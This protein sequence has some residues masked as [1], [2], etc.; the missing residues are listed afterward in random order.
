MRKNIFIKSMLRRP[1][2]T[3][4]L[5]ALI[6]L[7]TFAFVLRTVEFVIVRSQIMATAGEYRTLGFI[8]HPEWFGD[9]SEGIELISSSPYIARTHR[10]RAAEGILVD[11]LNADFSGMRPTL[12]QRRGGREN[13]PRLTE[14]YI[15]A[16]VLDIWGQQGWMQGYTVL[17]LLVDEVI[18]GHPEYAINGQYMTM[19]FLHGPFSYSDAF[20]NMVIGERYL[21]VG[22]YLRQYPGW[23]IGSNHPR[24]PLGPTTPVEGRE[25]DWLYI[26][27]LCDDGRPPNHTWYIHAPTGQEADFTDPRLAHIPAQILT[28]YRDQRSLQLQAVTDMTMMPEVTHAMR[29]REGRL[30]D[31]YDYIEANPVAVIDINF[32][33]NR[34]LE[35]GDTFKINI[36]RQQ[37]FVGAVTAPGFT[38]PL[39]RVDRAY[40]HRHEDA[41][42]VELTVVGITSFNTFTRYTTQSLFVFIPDSIL[43]DGFGIEWQQT[44]WGYWEDGRRGAVPMPP[45]EFGAV[46]VPDVWYSFVLHDSRAE[47]EFFENYHWQLYDLDLDLVVYFAESEIFWASAWPVLVTVIF[48]AVLFWVVLVLVLALV[49]F[50]FLRQKRG[51]FAIMRALGRPIKRIYIGVIAAALLFGLP[52]MIIGGAAGWF[53]AHREA[54]ATIVQFEEAYD[55]ATPLT[56]FEIQWQ[57]HFG[58]RPIPGTQADASAAGAGDGQGVGPDALDMYLLL[59]FIGIVLALMLILLTIGGIKMLRQPVLVQLQGNVSRRE[60]AVSDVHPAADKAAT[61]EGNIAVHS[62]ATQKHTAQQVLTATNEGNLAVHSMATQKHTAYELAL[63]ASSFCLKLSA[64]LRWTVRH[65]RRSPV[66]TV[67]GIAVTIFFIILLGWLQASIDQTNNEI[68]NLY[69][70][71]IVRAQVVMCPER[72]HNTRQFNDIIRSRTVEQVM[73]TGYIYTTYK[74]AVMD[75]SFV[76]AP[77]DGTLTPHWRAHIGMLPYI[78]GGQ[79]RLFA[80]DH[81]LGISDLDRFLQRHTIAQNPHMLA[82]QGD[83]DTYTAAHG[84]GGLRN[85]SIT[86]APGYDENIFEATNHQPGNPIPIIVSGYTLQNRGLSLGDAAL[87][88]FQRRTWEYVHA[89]IIGVHNEQIHIDNM[90]QS[91]IMPLWAF[92]YVFRDI[93]YRYAALE[94]GINPANN[95]NLPPVRAELERIINIGTTP[96]LLE[97]GGA[98]P[99]DAH[100]ALALLFSDGELKSLVSAM[101]QIL[102]ILELIHPIAIG[103]AIVIGTGLALLLMLQNAKNAAIMRVLGA[104]LTKTRLVLWS[105]Q[106]LISLIG[107]T[108]GLTVLVAAGQSLASMVTLAGLYFAGVVVGAST[109]GIIVTSKAPLDLLQVRE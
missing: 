11:M 35:L 80:M 40:P 94:L 47:R 13:L 74:E 5:V 29:L 86:F 93:P 103:L 97:S 109:G 28:R 10:R 36:P 83:M 4:L 106:I 9:I 92:E 38:T 59:I 85:I 51:E 43:P 78:A 30:I 68:E 99:E 25:T 50:V 79:L 18:T 88:G 1:L 17:E 105:E 70:T 95:R 8:N 81:T 90:Q 108:I 100:P 7:A 53:F 63:P 23:W 37:D 76:I 44:G 26:M 33:A 52:A 60:K 67:L 3:G 64:A 91:T 75:W 24:P 45:I 15:Y 84:V 87:V 32:A 107:L 58:D 31:E 16:Y 48:N 19:V 77:R 98:P 22:A 2:R 21:L 65:I 34:G 71:T 20:A 73:E 41:I 14:A 27:P 104:S 12:A 96:D 55:Q 72:G 66:K 56:L 62:K 102:L 89:K 39:V 101:R 82:D 57:A 54:E 6:A 42:E 49:A 61:N 69:N 46:H